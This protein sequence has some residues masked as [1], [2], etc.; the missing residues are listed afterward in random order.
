MAD[1]INH[2]QSSSWH[3][4]LIRWSGAWAQGDHT[5]AGRLR[6]DTTLLHGHSR[7]VLYVFT[8]QSPVGSE[9]SG[10]AEPSQSGTGSR[11]VRMSA[12]PRVKRGR[13]GGDSLLAS[14]SWVSSG[15]L[16]TMGSGSQH[17]LARYDGTVRMKTWTRAKRR[18]ELVYS[19]K[20]VRVMW[21]VKP[22]RQ[23]GHCRW[24]ASDR[25]N[26]NISTSRTFCSR[27]CVRAP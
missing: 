21:K 4:H 18:L 10:G 19:R 22:F 25:S 12:C 2:A 23:R 13:G 24:A 6:C 1:T 8:S 9:T 17:F 27:L 26:P 5:L 14:D 15:V 16:E 11:H 7:H 20:G 3:S